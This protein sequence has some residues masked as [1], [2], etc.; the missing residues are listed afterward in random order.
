M[1][2]YGK[3]TLQILEDRNGAFKEVAK[4]CRD[5]KVTYELEQNER[6]LSVVCPFLH[7]VNC[8]CL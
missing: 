8:K 3:L 7:R 4:R 2:P 1:L 6:E 5:G